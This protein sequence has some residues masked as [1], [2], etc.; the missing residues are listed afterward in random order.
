MQRALWEIPTP[1]LRG[2]A[3]GPE[4][5]VKVVARFY[6]DGPVTDRHRELVSLAETYL[7]ADFSSEMTSRFEAVQH[8][9]PSRLDLG[10]LAWWVYLRWEVTSWAAEGAEEFWE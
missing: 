5:G 8:P 10:T 9:I 7:L 6:Y 2:I 3:V 4:D 1:D